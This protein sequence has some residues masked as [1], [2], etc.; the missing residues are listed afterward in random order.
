MFF[1]FER[2]VLII[3]L[4]AIKL[5]LVLS[6]INVFISICSRKKKFFL[7]EL[8]ILLGFYLL[9]LSIYISFIKIHFLGAIDVLALTT[10]PSLSLIKAPSKILLS[11]EGANFH[12]IYQT[13]SLVIDFSNDG[14]L[15]FQLKKFNMTSELFFYVTQMILLSTASHLNLLLI[16]I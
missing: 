15:A 2:N 11:I 10:E 1:M 9:L 13:P 14:D 3:F 12:N 8:F 4:F 16:I 7:K 6:F 5:L